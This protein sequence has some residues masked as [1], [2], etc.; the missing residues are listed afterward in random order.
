MLGLPKL[1]ATRVA[2]ALGLVC[3]LLL[4]G[5]LSQL[6]PLLRQAGRIEWGLLLP[7]ALGILLE[8]TLPIVCLLGCGL[9]YGALRLDGAWDAALALGH[10][11]AV[12]LKPALIC[13]A[14]AA[15]L[16]AGLAHYATPTLIQ[17]V[18]TAIV[19]GLSALPAGARFA[20]ADG[21]AR[22]DADGVVH[23]VV[24]ATYIRAASP[25]I[26][27]DQ[28][29]IDA[30]DAWVW[31]PRVRAKVGAVTLRLDPDA[32]LRGL[33]QLGPPN[34]LP[35]AHLGA[36]AHHRFIAHRRTALP[37]L[38]VFWALLGGLLGARLG[39]LRAVLVGAAAVGLAYWI[40]RTGELSAR[41]QMM[42]AWLAAWAPVGLTGLVTLWAVLRMDGPQGAGRAA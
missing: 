39:G 32:R 19:D 2:M 35:T 33:G 14:L 37:V 11:P 31:S 40:L 16:S 1:I 26:R 17:H 23:A 30:T 12:L 38:A 28:A 8:P 20:L 41:A 22:V 25:V 9:A 29:R 13:G 6:A 42:P 18:R 7:A 24:G 36:S 27:L 34:S 10:R 15:S 3:V 5:Q 4:A 21:H